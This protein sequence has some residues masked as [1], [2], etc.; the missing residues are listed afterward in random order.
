MTPEERAKLDRALALAEENN[1]ILRGL[2]RANRVSTAMRIVYWVVILALSFGA[3]YFIQPY[4]TFLGGSLDS[5]GGIQGLQDKLN[6][7]QDSAG[8]LRDLLK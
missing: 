7:A 8:A 4:L 1:D 3:I 5:V 6:Q 2:R